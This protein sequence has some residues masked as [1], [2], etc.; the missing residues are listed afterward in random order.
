ML[1]IPA[2]HRNQTGAQKL[3]G[4]ANLTSAEGCAKEQPASTHHE[5]DACQGLS[6][7]QHCPLL[8]QEEFGVTV[9]TT[10]Q[11]KIEEGPWL[12]LDHLL[13]CKHYDWKTE[14]KGRWEARNG[15]TSTAWFCDLKTGP[16][17][18]TLW[19]LSFRF[20]QAHFSYILGNSDSRFNFDRKELHIRER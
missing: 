14:D 16:P 13:Y 9:Y 17:T 5:W 19:N 7:R 2:G 3:L 20:Q 6:L 15:H 1:E 4:K 10:D 11:F 8:W 18:Y 12:W